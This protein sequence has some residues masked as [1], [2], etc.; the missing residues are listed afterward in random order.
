MGKTSTSLYVYEYLK[1]YKKDVCYIGTHYV[2]YKNLKI[3]TNNTTLE[4]NELIKIFDEYK[5]APKYIVMEVSSHG[6]NQARING[7]K[8]DIIA[9][10]N[11]YSDHLDYHL[12]INNYHNVKI[13]FLNSII[14]CKHIL[15]NEKYKE[16]FKSKNI[17]FFNFHDDLLNRFKT[18]NYNRENMYLAYLILSKIFK[19]NNIIE[20]LN[21]IKLDN[22]RGEII[23]HNNRNIIID[24]AHQSKSFEKI[25][26]DG[27]FNKVVIFGC[28]GNR[29]NTKRSIMGEIACKYCNHVIITSDNS[30]NEPL[31]NIIND[32][33]R[34]IND[35][36]II[37]NRGKAIEYAI[38]NYPTFDIYILGKGD[39]TFIEENNNK[40]DFNDKQYVLDYLKHK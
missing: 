40:I 39:E 12:N 27:N 34:N 1:L 29:D 7:L 31:D 25:L 28:G 18:L 6:I 30:R 33:T 15:V 2:Y 26:N 4:Y 21:N 36:I 16:K 38:D 11:L 3:N 22:G 13:A 37:K 8:F 19:H 9:L 35:Y 5:I 24:Y 23:K 17:Y 20:Q 10:T 14:K 32:I